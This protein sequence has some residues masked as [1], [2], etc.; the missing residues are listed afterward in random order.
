LNIIASRK[1]PIKIL[2]EIC[3]LF[4]IFQIHIM[5][6]CESKS[7]AKFL[8]FG[9]AYFSKFSLVLHLALIVVES[10]D[11]QQTQIQEQAHPK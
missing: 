2:K 7:L 4:M 11:V 8:P 10:I 5:R 9:D 3:F 6:I 1:I